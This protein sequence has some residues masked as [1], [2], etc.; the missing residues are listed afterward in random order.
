MV[1]ARGLSS[2]PR[3]GKTRRRSRVGIT[4]ASAVGNA[5][6]RNRLRRRLK[7]ILDGYGLDRPPWQDVVLIARPGAGE[8]PF[9]ALRDEMGRLYRRPA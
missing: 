1:P 7:A 6:V 9:A 4:V 5:V 8:L 2:C 3:G